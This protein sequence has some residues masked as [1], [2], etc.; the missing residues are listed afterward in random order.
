MST[1]PTPEELSAFEEH[2]KTTAWFKVLSAAAAA[3]D[4]DDGASIFRMA[5]MAAREAWEA[6]L[7]GQAKSAAPV[8]PA[9]MSAFDAARDDVLNDRGPLE[10]EAM[11]TEQTNAVLTI[12]DGHF[13]PHLKRGS[14]PAAIPEAPAQTEAKYNRAREMADEVMAELEATAHA[15]TDEDVD[16][17]QG[18]LLP[19]VYDCLNL[20]AIAATPS[21]QDT[22]PPR[23]FMDH[24]TWHDRETGKHLFYEG[25][26]PEAATVNAWKSP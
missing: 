4:D 20:L 1:T 19:R 5:R 22:N 6:A 16:R 13:M 14:T 18:T 11:T 8:E 26:C 12:L 3:D 9:W 23:F 15:W 7:A 25:E 2:I 24:G 10:G 21:H 17:I